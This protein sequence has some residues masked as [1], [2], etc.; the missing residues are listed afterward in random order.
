M[1]IDPCLEHDALDL[2]QRKRWGKSSRL[3]AG[4]GAGNAEGV[5]KR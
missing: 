4:G 5:P 2:R 3:F 1:P